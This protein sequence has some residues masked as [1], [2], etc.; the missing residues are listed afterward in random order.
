MARPLRIQAA[1]LT[2]HVTA[3]GVGKADIFLDDSERRVFLKRLAQVVRRFNV[4]CHAYCQM[5]NH[6]HLA[7]TTLEPNLSRAMQYL[8]GRYAQWWNRKHERVGH[9]F[10]ARFHSQVIQDDAY[11]VNACKYIALN[12]VR[13]GMVSSPEGWPWS[14][15]RAMVGVDRMPQFMDCNHVMRLVAPDDPAAGPK[16]LRDSLTDV[17]AG[18]VQ[19]PRAAIVGDDEF[20]A[21]FHSIIARAHRERPLS[22]G[23]RTLDAIFNGAITRAERNRAMETALR[24]RY[25]ASEVARYLGLHPSTV[26]KITSVMDDGDEEELR[27]NA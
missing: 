22:A 13:A 21:R 5:T 6:Y 4:L 11:L 25:A 16:R 24:E 20:V 1:G 3:R 17:D 10:Q 27:A 26:S 7:I 14:S 15:Y 2:Y 19:F 23:R 9:V 12:P 8:N 18:A